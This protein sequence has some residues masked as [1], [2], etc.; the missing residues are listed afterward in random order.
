MF[1]GPWKQKPIVQRWTTA[2]GVAIK[3]NADRTLWAATEVEVA[4]KVVV[5]SVAV[6]GKVMV[7]VIVIVM[8]MVVA[9]MKATGVV[10]VTGVVAGMV[11]IGTNA[12]L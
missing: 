1:A 9:V 4:E 12:F 6:K 2:F 5:A 8:V 3:E 11:K 10:K 7:M